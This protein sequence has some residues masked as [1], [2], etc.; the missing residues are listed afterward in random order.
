MN[1]ERRYKGIVFLPSKVHPN[2]GVLNRYYGVMENGKGKLRGIEI[3]R[4]DTPRF[5]YDAQTEMINVLA[6]S[7]NTT[8]YLA[9]IPE[10]LDVIKQYRSKLLNDEVPV[11]D[12]IVTKHLSKQSRKYKQ[13]VSQVI[14]AEQ[15]IKE[16][17]EVHAGK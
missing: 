1:F 5:I 13:Q 15:L 7:N 8:E 10:A 9:K 17:R 14:A 6:S 16:G 2:I 11:W 12:L 4:H 3:R